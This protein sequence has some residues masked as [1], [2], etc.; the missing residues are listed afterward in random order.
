MWTTPNEFVYRTPL[1]AYHRDIL[2]QVLLKFAVPPAGVAFVFDN[3]DYDKYLNTVWRD[4]QALHM[5]I[6]LGGVEEMSPR[7]LVDIMKSKKHA[8][9]VWL[10]RRIC[11]GPAMQFAWVLAHELRHLEQD[12]LSHA[13]SRAGHF[14]QSA[15]CFMPIDEPRICVTI[16]T[17]LDAE[18][19]AR[20]TVSSIFGLAETN[21]Y[22]ALEVEARDRPECYRVLP[23][24][25]LKEE[26]DVV[27][28]TL[29]MLMKYR[30]QLL[31]LQETCKDPFISDFNVQATCED[32]QGLWNSLM[33]TN[34]ILNRLRKTRAAIDQ[35][36]IPSGPGVYAIF[37]KPGA[38]L[39]YYRLPTDDI[40][41]IG[42]SQDLPS[43]VGGT[44]FDSKGSGFSTLRRSIG[45]LLKDKLQLEA[46]PSGDG[47]DDSDYTQYC[48]E[49]DGEERLTEWMKDT[50]EVGVCPLHEDEEGMKA[51]EERL[52]QQARP[53]L[54]LRK[55]PNPYAE[56]I[57]SL[58]R[59]CAEEARRKEQ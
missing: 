34:G 19:A 56:F 46:I 33:R 55:W 43:R 2:E 7:H 38:G 29:R 20:R 59:K 44:H 5:N 14:L 45:A 53:V 58:R 11:G 31:D 47:G 10:S 9:L 21:R 52:I 16:P 8:H 40:M 12:C 57:E 1:S 48:F 28:K 26:Y 23:E 32:L 54:N 49:S 36:N 30:Q 22:I 17:E 3:D 24:I 15:F 13:L 51:W 41:Y 27:G 18:L 42:V 25:N 50:L 6:Q 4:N 37:A 35:L 39:S